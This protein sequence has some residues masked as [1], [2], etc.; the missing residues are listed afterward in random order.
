MP[1]FE[2]VVFDLDGT[3]LD[4]LDDLHLSTNAVL[5]AHDMPAR[6][7]DE[8]RRFVGNGI[9]LLIHRA[10]PEGTPADVE[11]AVLADFR[12]HYGA[13][14]EDHTGPYPGIPELLAHLRAAGVRVAVVSNKADF[15]VQE[16]VA[17]QFP[18]TFDAVLGECEERGVRK[19]PAPDMVEAA[20]KR[21]E[22][23]AGAPSQDDPS[24]A[25]RAT[26]AYVG[27]SEVDVA[28]AANVGCAC[29]GCAWGF[30]G[31]ESLL[32]SGATVVVDTP[33]EL[34]RVLLAGK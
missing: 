27:D 21:M 16:L 12:R 22:A 34:E 17:R 3:L 4:T 19:K 7:L 18:D 30:R 14:C 26:L 31:R 1:A 10:V 32:A 24:P 28:T 11:A 2:T 20:L 5:A 23:A 8:V 6:T 33:A 15:A 9:A 29:V 25:D 13:H